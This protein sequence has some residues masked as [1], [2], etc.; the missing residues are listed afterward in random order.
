MTKLSVDLSLLERV[1][2]AL[3]EAHTK[4]EHL[5]DRA[6]RKVIMTELK[7]LIPSKTVYAWE[8]NDCGSQE[9]TMAVSEVY[10]GH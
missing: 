5:Q 8:C 2:N 4:L 3:D 10:L 1:Y 7:K 9:Y 6:A